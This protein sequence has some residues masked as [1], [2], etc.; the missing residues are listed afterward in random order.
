MQQTRSPLPS[1]RSPFQLLSIPLTLSLPSSSNTHRRTYTHRTQPHLQHKYKRA[2]GTLGTLGIE[3][4]MSS[5]TFSGNPNMDPSLGR[6]GN[7]TTNV[8][9]EVA[10]NGCNGRASQ[11]PPRRGQVKKAIAAEVARSF[12][13]LIPSATVSPSPPETPPPA[14]NRPD[15]SRT[16]S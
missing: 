9:Y 3:A 11:P 6:P 13:R 16:C 4:F 7:A 1:S 15:Q 12:S 8:I 2:R 5:I 10:F 14:N